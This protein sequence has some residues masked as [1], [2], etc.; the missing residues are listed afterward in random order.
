MTFV[1]IGALRVNYLVANTEGMFSCENKILTTQHAEKKSS[2]M[3][4]N[5]SNHLQP[6]V[7]MTTRANSTSKQAPIAQNICNKQLSLY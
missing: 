1:A 2:G 5:P 7:G 4:E 3:A 6:S